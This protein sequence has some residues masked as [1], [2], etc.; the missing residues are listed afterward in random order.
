MTKQFLVKSTPQI[1]EIIDSV[2]NITECADRSKLVHQLLLPY[3]LDVIDS[4]KTK[5]DNTEIVN[6]EVRKVFDS[7]YESI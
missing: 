2:L 3:I 7:Y 6:S 5:M 1:V 4:D